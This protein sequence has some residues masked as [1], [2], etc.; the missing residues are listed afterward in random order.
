M[1]RLIHR[2]LLA[3]V[4]QPLATFMDHIDQIQDGSDVQKLQIDTGCELEFLAEHF[5]IMHVTIQEKQRELSRSRALIL[6]FMRTLYPM[7]KRNFV[8]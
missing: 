5:S 1:Q 4:N 2:T 7:Y 3:Q 8:S 6:K